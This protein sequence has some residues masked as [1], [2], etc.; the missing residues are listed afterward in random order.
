MNQLNNEH[1]TGK[2]INRIKLGCVKIN[3]NCIPLTRLTKRKIKDK[4][5]TLKSNIRRKICLQILY[6]SF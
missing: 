5:A 3:E 6:A 2:K 1:N 4:E